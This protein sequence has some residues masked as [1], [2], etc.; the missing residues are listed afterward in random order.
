M[1]PGEAMQGT[2]ELISSTDRP[3]HIKVYLE[4][5]QYT[6][7]GDGSKQFA[8]PGTLPRSAAPWITF[9]PREIDIPARGQILVEYSIRVPQDPALSGGY[10]AVL[11]FES[12]I[13]EPATT[14]PDAVTVKYSAPKSEWRVKCSVSTA[15][16]P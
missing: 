14:G 5:W 10:Y 16:S 6:P 7:A 2:I 4:D 12:E 11:F 1:A 3:I 9:F 13:N 15:F 8:P